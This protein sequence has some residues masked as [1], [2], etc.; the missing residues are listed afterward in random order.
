MCSTTTPIFMILRLVTNRNHRC[1][2]TTLLCCRYHEIFVFITTLEL[3]IEIRLTARLCSLVPKEIH[4]FLLFYI[5]LFWLCF[6]G[7]GFSCNPVCIILYIWKCYSEQGSRGFTRALRAL[8]LEL[9]S[10]HCLGKLPVTS[11]RPR[12][13]HTPLR[14]LCIKWASVSESVIK[15]YFSIV[16]TR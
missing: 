2:Q 16:L 9:C 11:H 7:T 15:E 4:I 5:F 12:A 14:E 6:N 8:S 13:L 10:G 1:F 3:T